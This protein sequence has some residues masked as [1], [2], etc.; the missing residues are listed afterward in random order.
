MRPDMF[1]PLALLIIPPFFF[2]L[3][4]KNRMR[5]F[6]TKACT[7]SATLRLWYWMFMIYLCFPGGWTFV[8]A[9]LR[10]SVAGGLRDGVHILRDGADGIQAPALSSW[11][12]GISQTSHFRFY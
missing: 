6:S 10:S 2:V 9:M 3:F 7:E 8:C 5:R 11:C 12:V 4:L 1:T